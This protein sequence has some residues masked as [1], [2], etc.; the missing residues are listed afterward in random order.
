MNLTIAPIRNVNEKSS[1]SG[2]ERTQN[3]N[4]GSNDVVT[5]LPK[6]LRQLKSPEKIVREMLGIKRTLIEIYS[7]TNGAMDPK[8][9]ELL[10]QR[11]LAD[12]GVNID[13]DLS[14]NVTKDWRK[15]NRLQTIQQV[16]QL[17]KILFP[18]G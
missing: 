1:I 13:S 8:T 14:K 9:D 16:D 11:I 10:M 15:I 18:K 5:F 6:G 4:F 12:N 3:L 2:L 7:Q 17:M